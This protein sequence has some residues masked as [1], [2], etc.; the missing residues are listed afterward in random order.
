MGALRYHLMRWHHWCHRSLH[1]NP[2]GALRKPSSHP[3]VKLNIRP[4]IP[5]TML[6]RSWFSFAA[7]EVLALAGMDPDRRRGGWSSLHTQ[8]LSMEQAELVG[9]I[10]GT[11]CRH[12]QNFSSS[13]VKHAAQ[14]VLPRVFHTEWASH[15][16]KIEQ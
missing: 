6:L 9:E 7:H 15:P 16:Q 14:Q 10:S 8:C 11:Y 1:G 5:S 3:M 4:F 2:R 13:C 12:R